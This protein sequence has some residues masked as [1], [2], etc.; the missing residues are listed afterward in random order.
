MRWALPLRPSKIIFDPKLCPPAA[1]SNSCAPTLATRAGLQCAIAIG[2]DEELRQSLSHGTSALSQRHIICHR[3]RFTMNMEP[4]LPAR[5][6]LD[7]RIRD[8]TLHSGASTHRRKVLHRPKQP[9]RILTHVITAIL[10][11]RTS[12]TFLNCQQRLSGWHAAST[13]L[14]LPVHLP[15]ADR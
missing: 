1:I 3:C 7:T 6:H 8:G 13:Y 5:H 10:F 9:V 15:I 14:D 2:I 4:A 11:F 12:I